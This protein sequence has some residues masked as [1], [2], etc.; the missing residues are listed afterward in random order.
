MANEW[1]VYRVN[2]NTG[3]GKRGKSNWSINIHRKNTIFTISG[4]SIVRRN[5]MV[6]FIQSPIVSIVKWLI[7][8]M[9]FA[10]YKT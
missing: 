8:D 4:I 3:C 5:N 9:P 6:K 2:V 1:F 10:T 7:C